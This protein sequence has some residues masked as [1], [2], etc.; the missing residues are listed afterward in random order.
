MPGANTIAQFAEFIQAVGGTGLVTTDYGS[1][2]P[3]EAEAELA[4]L[5][6]SPTD[7]TVIGTGIEWNDGTGA[8]QNVNWQ[9]VGYWA[10]LRRVAAWDR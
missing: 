5:E 1:G 3:Q 8:W 6:G 10:S 9:T 2:S 7:T 4:Y